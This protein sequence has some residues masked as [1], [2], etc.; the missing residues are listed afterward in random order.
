VVSLTPR[1]LYHRERAIGTHWIGGWMG[2]RTVPD[3]V[4]KRKIHS[5]CRDSKPSAI[6]TELSQ[7]LYNGKK[8]RI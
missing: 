7:L 2:S 4:V 8:I 1:P 3:A 5:L 6:P